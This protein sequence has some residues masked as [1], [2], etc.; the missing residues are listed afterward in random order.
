[1][2]IPR[3]DAVLQAD[4]SL[5]FALANLEEKPKDAEGKSGRSSPATPAKKKK[6]KSNLDNALVP[7]ARV[8]TQRH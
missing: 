3:D 8:D 6:D 2:L 4:I 7:P 5:T 1:M